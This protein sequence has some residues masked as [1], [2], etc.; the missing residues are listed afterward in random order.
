M[1]SSEVKLF[2]NSMSVLFMRANLAE[3]SNHVCS[4]IP[5]FTPERT[6]VLATKPQILES[7]ARMRRSVIRS[8]IERIDIRGVEIAQTSEL[9]S[10]V[11]FHMIFLDAYGNEKRQSDVHAILRHTDMLGQFQIELMEWKRMSFP[12]LFEDIAKVGA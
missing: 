10:R 11:N 8:A 7:F 2:L 9:R 12:S 5:L 6:I 3:A 4:P 1:L